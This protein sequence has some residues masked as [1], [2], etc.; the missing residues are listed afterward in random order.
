MDI[1]GEGE[2][3]LLLVG[4]VDGLYTTIPPSQVFKN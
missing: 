4:C 3:L 1:L 2:C